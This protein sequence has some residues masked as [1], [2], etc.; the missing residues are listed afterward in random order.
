VTPDR[1]QML[2]VVNDLLAVGAHRGAALIRFYATMI[3]QRETAEVRDLPE[4][5]FGR[6]VKAK[7]NP[8]AANDHSPAFSEQPSA[9][10][11]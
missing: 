9:P 2:A 3:A 11:A 5:P 7:P 6:R 4:R 1:I 8:D 10:F